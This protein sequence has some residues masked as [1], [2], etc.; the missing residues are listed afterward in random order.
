MARRPSAR[1]AWSP[2][3]PPPDPPRAYVIVGYQVVAG[4]TV[5]AA[6]WSTGLTGWH[7]AGDAVSATGAS[8]ALDGPGA[9]RQMRAVTAA[10]HGFIAVGADGDA[11][12][13]WAS[14]DGGRTWTQQ[15]VPLPVGAV[16]AVLTQ[17]ASNGAAVVAVGYRAHHRRPAAPVRGELV[18]RRRH[19]DR[20]R[21]AGAR[22]PGVCSPR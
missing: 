5:A 22:G 20:G 4:R 19:L 6:W 15:N 21:P 12:A 13:A 2:S 7:R 3:K 18:R 16:R 17:V 1:P 9:S 8:G 14:A 10:G 11:P